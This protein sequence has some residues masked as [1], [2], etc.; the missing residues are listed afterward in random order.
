MRRSTVVAIAGALFVFMGPAH[1]RG[2]R[3]LDNGGASAGI[4]RAASPL[5]G[6]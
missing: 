5:A 4:G 6:A 3:D 1:E 2:P